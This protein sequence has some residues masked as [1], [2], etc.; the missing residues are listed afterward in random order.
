MWEYN[1]TPVWNDLKV[2]PQPPPLHAQKGEEPT[3]LVGVGEGRGG[4]I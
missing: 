2:S 1:E 4:Q 3:L